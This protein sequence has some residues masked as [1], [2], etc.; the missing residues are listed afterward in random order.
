MSV[1]QSLLLSLS[2]RRRT[3]SYDVVNLSLL[4]DYLEGHLTPIGSIIS[5]LTDTGPGEGW[6]QISGQSLIKA[7][8]P[9]LYAEIGGKFGEDNDTFNLPNLSGAYLTGASSSS[10]S[11]IGD[12][13]I[14]LTTLQIPPH[15]HDVT[16][17]GH[18]HDATSPPH[19][20][21]ITDPG[22]SH[23]SGEVSSAAGTDG[24][25]SGVS[26]GNT[27]SATTGITVDNA[28]STVSVQSAMAGVTVNQSGGGQPFNNRPY[29]IEVYYFIKAKM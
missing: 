26:S 7:D 15:T 21:T 23:S 25:D 13:E 27:G 29:S 24:S 17:N 2:A 4:G 6:V 1:I 8:F 10:G 14:T 5:K 3:R 16:D 9:Q 12:N 11:F 18:T 19:N 28:T 20:H 22:H